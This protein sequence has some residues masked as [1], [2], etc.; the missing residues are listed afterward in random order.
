M[1]IQ[2]IELLINRYFE[3][4]ATKEEEQTL[5]R[6]LA[7]PSTP[8]TPAIDEA[9]AV[10]AF[11]AISRP[12]ASKRNDKSSAVIHNRAAILKAAAAAALL[13]SV[14]WGA[15]SDSGVEA[16]SE[17]FAAVYDRGNFSNS[18]D[19]ALSIMRSQLGAMGQESENGATAK[20]IDLLDAMND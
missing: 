16:S 14:G 5:K 7:D 15:V 2:Y 10:M 19:V 13:I 11:S 9:R 8:S 12:A 20:A 3:A 6:L 1:N 4:T 17:S 18:T